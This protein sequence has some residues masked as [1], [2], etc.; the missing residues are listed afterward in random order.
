M[1]YEVSVIDHFSAAHQIR[2]THDKCERLHGHNWQVVVWVK[3]KKLDEHDLV[4]DFRILKKELKKCLDTLDHNFINELSAFKGINA[5]SENIACYIYKQLAEAI[6][7][8]R[9]KVSKVKV[10]E[11]HNSFAEYIDD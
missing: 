3:A 4:I 6:N 1:S 9:I 2:E 8:K 5:T 10:A 7:T 11:S